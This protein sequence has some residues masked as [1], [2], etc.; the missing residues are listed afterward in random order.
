MTSQ[1]DKILTK[2]MTRSSGRKFLSSST[3]KRSKKKK[4]FWWKVIELKNVFSEKK[5]KLHYLKE[6]WDRRKVDL[7]GHEFESLCLCRIE[8]KTLSVGMNRGDRWRCQGN[9]SHLDVETRQ[10]YRCTMHTAYRGSKVLGGC[11][12]LFHFRQVSGSCCLNHF[13]LEISSH[14]S[15]GSTKTV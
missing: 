7:S 12:S 2:V 11:G 14:L 6:G 9:H 1:R 13:W 15:L 8:I 3:K 4:P 5:R 10:T